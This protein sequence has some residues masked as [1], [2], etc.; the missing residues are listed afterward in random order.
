VKDD[1][2]TTTSIVL[3]LKCPLTCTRIKVPCR[4]K[5]CKHLQCVDARSFLELNAQTPTWQC[6]VC[7]QTMQSW[8]DLVRDDYFASILQETPEDQESVLI[9]E[10]GNW[11]IP[12][13]KTT[14]TIQ[15]RKSD[16]IALDEDSS[17]KKAPKR[18]K[19]VVYIDL[20][21]SSDEEEGSTA[22]SST[23]TKNMPVSKTVWDRW[24]CVLI[25][26]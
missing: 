20:T 14:P 26:D 6:P 24:M 8:E 18:K 23:T 16:V 11:S 10:E 22:S 13:P 15:K 19:E 4:F 7:N 21:L 25:L 1:E 12:P 9:D 3:S 2:I 17:D 5:T